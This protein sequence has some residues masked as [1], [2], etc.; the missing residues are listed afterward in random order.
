MSSGTIRRAGDT[1]RPDA[2]VDDVL[3]HHPAEEQVE[4]LAGAAGRGA[5]KE[6]AHPRALRQRVRRPGAGRS[7]ARAS[8]TSR[9]PRPTSGD[10][11]SSPSTKKR[12]I[13][14]DSR[15][16]RCRMRSSAARSLPR[17]QRC[18]S[19]ARRTRPLSGS[20]SRTNAAGCGPMTASSDSIELKHAGDAAEGE[21]GRAEPDDLA[22]RR[23]RGIAGRCARDRWPNSGGRR[24]D[25]GDRAARATPVLRADRVNH[26]FARRVIASPV[27]R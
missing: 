7:R 14:P 9:A 11:G 13:E 21:P 1:P 22:I 12:S 20:N 18:T 6:V 19:G 27:R 15:S 4:A 2:Q 3:A 16:I 5:R 17:I 24:C 10:A 8:R 26:A 25:R 23:D